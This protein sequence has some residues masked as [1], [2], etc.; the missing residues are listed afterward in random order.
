MKNQQKKKATMGGREESR[1]DYI[2]AYYSIHIYAVRTQIELY[3]IF[4]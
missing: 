2:L 4:C 3:S 1:N